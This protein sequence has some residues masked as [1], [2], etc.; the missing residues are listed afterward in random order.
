MGEWGEGSG[1]KRGRES[2]KQTLLSEEPDEDTEHNLKTLR[3]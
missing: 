3:S 2:P 1:G